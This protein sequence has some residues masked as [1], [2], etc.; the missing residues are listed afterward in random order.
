MFTQLHVARPTISHT[1]PQKGFTFLEILVVVAMVAILAGTAVS[2]VTHYIN[3]G[4]EEARK[5]EFHNILSAVSVMKFHNNI[6]SIP[7]ID[8]V[9]LAPCTVGKKD[10]TAFPDITSDTGFG[11][12]G[13]G[14]KIVDPTGY[15]YMFVGKK[16]D[17]DIQGYLL[18]GHDT[19]GSDGSELLVNYLFRPTTNYCY[20]VGSDGTVHQ[21][22]EDG[23]EQM[24]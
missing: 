5:T 4:R 22:L 16:E 19:T 23:T 2:I 12:G 17:R 11:A 24:P 6:T 21:Y 3:E 7:N 9:S 10:M 20:T 15:P 8:P 1:H 14:G 13:D 18:Y